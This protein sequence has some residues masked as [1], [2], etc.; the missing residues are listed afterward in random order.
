MSRVFP[1][2][3]CDLSTPS[4]ICLVDNVRQTPEKVAVLE[5]KLP[6]QPRDRLLMALDPPILQDMPDRHSSSHKMP[7]EQNASGWPAGPSRRTASRCGVSAR[8]SQCARAPVEKESCKPA[9]RIAPSHS[10]NR[11][12]PPAARHTPSGPRNRPARSVQVSYYPKM[13]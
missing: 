9:D 6:E 7:A 5:A 2:R 3:I 12:D 11:F 4:L 8:H 10:D 1:L 13:A